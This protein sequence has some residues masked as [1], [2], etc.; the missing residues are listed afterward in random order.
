MHPREEEVFDWRIETGPVE[1]P[2]GPQPDDLENDAF[3]FVT[4]ICGD[5][6][7]KCQM[8]ELMDYGLNPE[9]IRLALPFQIR[10][11]QLY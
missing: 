1:F 8:L 3:A 9:V 6:S 11:S 5:S 2:N 4:G 7:S 10:C